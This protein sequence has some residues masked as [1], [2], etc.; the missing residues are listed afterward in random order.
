MKYTSIIAYSGWIAGCTG[1]V[2]NHVSTYITLSKMVHKPILGWEFS[3]IMKPGVR[4]HHSAG[5]VH[6]WMIGLTPLYKIYGGLLLIL[7]S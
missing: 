7:V 1:A 3:I 5:L 4:M 6:M 2:K